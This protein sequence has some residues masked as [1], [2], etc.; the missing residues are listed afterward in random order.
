MDTNYYNR[1]S[2]DNYEMSQ[3][4][5][6]LLEYILKPEIKG[7]HIISLHELVDIQ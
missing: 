5:K 7:H 1:R 4:I 3:N 6:T 2:H